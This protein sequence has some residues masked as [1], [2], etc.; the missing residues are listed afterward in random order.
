MKPY[1]KVQKTIESINAKWLDI[2][3]KLIE[4]ITSDEIYIIARKMTKLYE[5]LDSI[6]IDKEVKE[7][8]EYVKIQIAKEKAE[9]EKAAEIELQKTVDIISKMVINKLNLNWLYFKLKL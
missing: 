5:I 1:K 2:N 6:E 9:K 7:R 3:N 8:V 4:E